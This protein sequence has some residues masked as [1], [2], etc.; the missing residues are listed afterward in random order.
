MWEME[1][2][3]HGGG[4]LED[5]EV[6]VDM[7][8]V[9]GKNETGSLTVLFPGVMLESLTFGSVNK[10]VG[11]RDGWMESIVAVW[12]SSGEDCEVCVMGGKSE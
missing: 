3:G 2:S 11:G 1:L 6:E 7:C 4:G 8:I 9:E 5:W 12:R 10:G